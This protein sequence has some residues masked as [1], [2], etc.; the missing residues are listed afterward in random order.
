MQSKL[1]SWSATGMVDGGVLGGLLWEGVHTWTCM[2]SAG[3]RDAHA[4]KKAKCMS[5]Y[6]RQSLPQSAANDD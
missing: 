1:G 4:R 2:T 6:A 5:D 3:T